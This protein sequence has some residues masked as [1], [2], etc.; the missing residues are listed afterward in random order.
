[1]KKFLNYI[2]VV[3]LLTIG[4]AYTL[5]VLYTGVYTYGAARTKTTLALQ[6]KEK[7]FDVVFL[8]SSR[9]N[10]HFDTAIFE[11]NGLKVYNFGMS[12]AQL[13]ENLL[14]LKLLIANKTKIH[15]L[16]LQV[17]TNL[18]DTYI[19]EGTRVSFYPFIDE[20]IIS[21][22]YENK[23]IN[24]FD[25]FKNVPFYRYMKYDSR[26]GFRETALVMAKFHQK[27]LNEANL[28]FSPLLGMGQ[29]MSYNLANAKPLQKH[30]YYEEIKQICIKENIRFVPVTTPI[31][32]NSNSNNFFKKIKAYYPE[33]KELSFVV[34][35]DKY[36]ESC[37]HMNV[38]GAQIFSE[39]VYDMFFNKQN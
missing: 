23:Q 9:A 31:C 14:L 16:V 27:T 25:Y 22:Y 5:D 1:M 30:P 36:F 19:S 34:T 20:D 37:G 10:N 21:S 11:G 26:I 6:E 7:E 8:G 28:G 2:G 15:T 13:E 18:I 29:N 24:E 33:I 35:D 38:E 17:D 3:F 4:I 32:E 12:G 39:Y